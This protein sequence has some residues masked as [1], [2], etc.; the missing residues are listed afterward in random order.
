MES[1]T[2]QRPLGDL[3]AELA[4]ETGTLVRTEMVLAKAEMTD[5]AKIAARDAAVVAVGGA[6]AA[7]GAMALLAAVILALGALIPLWVAALLV[8]TLVS[9]AGGALVAL[10]VRAFKTIDP[11][12]RQLIQT[13]EEDKR[14]LREQMSR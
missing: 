12:P 11:R 6:I 3:F 5:K 13:H 2:P 9:I 1:A 10:G 4:S 14:W 8:G 7:L